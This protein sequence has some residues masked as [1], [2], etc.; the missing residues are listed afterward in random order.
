MHISTRS[1]LIAT[2]YLAVHTSALPHPLSY[3]VVNV[4]GG[5]QAAT[6]L[7][8]TI[9][10]TVT[11]SDSETTTVVQIP[12]TTAV[13]TD[14]TTSWSDVEA[15]ETA[16]VPVVTAS[17]PFPTF[18]GPPPIPT[19]PAPVEDST[20]TVISTVTPSPTTTTSYYD[21]G[22]W[23]TTYPI[24]AY[25]SVV[26]E[27]WSSSAAPSSYAAPVSYAA[28]GTGAALYGRAQPTGYNYG[29]GYAATGWARLK[30][31]AIPTGYGGYTGYGA[32]GW[33]STGYYRR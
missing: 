8:E 5:S 15:T 26:P 18:Y 6:P 4:D 1:S 16:L 23:H 12:T 9:Y 32:G 33:N 28:T 13:I 3:S 22:M 31:R 2:L 19:S 21:D 7:P 29:Y 10:Q 20:V 11:E 30:G 14:Y 27:A 24:K 17:P 25:S